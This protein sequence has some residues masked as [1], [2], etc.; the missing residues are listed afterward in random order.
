[1]KKMGE[2]AILEMYFN[3]LPDVVKNAAEP[4]SKVDKITMYGDSRSSNLTGDIINTVT[5]VTDGV[6]ETTGVDLPSIIAGFLGGK[7]IGD[8]NAANTAA[9]SAEKETNKENK[10]QDNI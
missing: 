8:L 10:I 1:M 5:K 9:A 7:T 4:L 2:A 3:T 6:K